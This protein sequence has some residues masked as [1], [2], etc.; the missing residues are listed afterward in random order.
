MSL[1]EVR[2]LHIRIDGHHLVRGVDLQIERGECL[3][4]VGESGSGKSLTALSLMQLLP[5]HARCDF[6]RW[7]FDGQSLLGTT[8]AQWRRLRASR[9]GMVFQNPMTALNPTMRVGD[10]I[11]EVLREHSRCSAR[12]AR[13]HALELL[14]R[15]GIVNA[16]KRARQYPFEL[17]GGMLQRAVIAMAV[18]CKPALLIADEPTTALDVTVQAEVLA[19]L[20]E[21][22]RDQHVGL[23]LITHDLGVVEAMAEQV[24]VMYAGRIVEAGPCQAVLS[25]P[26]HPYTR[27]LQQAMPRLDDRRDSLLAISGTPPDLSQQLNGCAFTPRCERAMQICPVRQPAVYAPSKARRCECWLWEPQAQGAGR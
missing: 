26:A 6:E 11:G 1:L 15:L 4:L 19:L 12:E 24:A 2:D 16:A 5:R 9:I 3:A 14:E 23:L 22:C 20:R 18:A 7:Q 21:L 27:A 8:E 10:Q 13:R 25:E 17:S